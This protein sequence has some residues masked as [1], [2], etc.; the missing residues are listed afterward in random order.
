MLK[1]SFFKLCL[2]AALWPVTV[3]SQSPDKSEESAYDYRDRTW[4]TAFNTG[5]FFEERAK[6]QLDMSIEYSGDDY[7]YPVYAVAVRGGCTSLDKGDARKLCGDR[8][9]ARM[10]RSPFIGDAPKPRT[11]GQVLYSFLASKNVSNDAQLVLA[12][13]EHKLEWLEADIS[14]CQPAIAHLSTA[15]EL[16][17]FA[18]TLLT[19]KSVL[20]IVSH[21]DKI[22]FDFRGGHLTKSSYQGYLKQG[23]PGEW[24]NAFVQ[25]LE[26]CWTESEAPTP[27]NV[28]TSEEG[29]D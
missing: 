7:R 28:A 29:R 13:D 19:D 27:W 8:L 23:S 10:V 18:S 6:H 5:N 14:S 2:V 9:T 22:A 4:Q 11:R 1:L 25:S 16:P 24:A 17:F 21:A 15:P 12:F 20:P 26:S 3:Y